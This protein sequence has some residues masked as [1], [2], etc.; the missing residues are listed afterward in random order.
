MPVFSSWKWPGLGGGNSGRLMPLWGLPIQPDILVVNAY[1]DRMGT[2]MF[3][4]FGVE[5]GDPFFSVGCEGR[6][7]IQQGDPFE[8]LAGFCFIRCKLDVKI[9]QAIQAMDN[10][11]WGLVWGF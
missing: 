1:L 5:E 11:F 9:C 2:S 8:S 3:P 10:I 6:A 4:H 7:G